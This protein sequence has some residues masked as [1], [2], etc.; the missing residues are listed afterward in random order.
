MH[1]IQKSSQPQYHVEAACLPPELKLD[2]KEKYPHKRGGQIKK[3]VS[4]FEV[5]PRRFLFSTRAHQPLP[6]LLYF[7]QAVKAKTSRPVLLLCMNANAQ[8]LQ[9]MRLTLAL[10]VEVYF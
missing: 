3:E 9:A 5:G 1:H 10:A 7:C 6:L 8:T 2:F 4:L